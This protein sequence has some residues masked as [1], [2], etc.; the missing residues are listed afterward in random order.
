MTVMSAAF[1]YEKWWQ[2]LL[3]H[4]TTTLT[5]MSPR[6]FYFMH[7][8][9]EQNDRKCATYHAYVYERFM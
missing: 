1:L 7:I 2:K 5:F 6:T 8:W 4:Y 3:Q 9:K